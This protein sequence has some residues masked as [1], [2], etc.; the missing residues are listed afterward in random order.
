M[1]WRDC[2]DTNRPH[3]LWHGDDLLHCAYDMERKIL[4]LL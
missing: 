4:L 1:E 2:T 3:Y